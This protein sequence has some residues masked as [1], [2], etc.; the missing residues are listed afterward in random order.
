MTLADLQ[1]ESVVVMVVPAAVGVAFSSFPKPLHANLQKHAL[2]DCSKPFFFFS[3]PV[4]QS[5]SQVSQSPET[6]FFFFESGPHLTKCTTLQLQHCLPLFSTA[7][8]SARTKQRRST[9]Y[10]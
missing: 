4:E 3:E 5:L 9:S 7:Q 8:S 2:R 6:F 1:W 10:L